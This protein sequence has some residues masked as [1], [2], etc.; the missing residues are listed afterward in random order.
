M[1][2]KATKPNTMTVSIFIFIV[3][4][5]T[6]TAVQRFSRFERL[7]VDPNNVTCYCEPDRFNTICLFCDS[8]EAVGLNAE[9]ARAFMDKHALCGEIKREKLK[10]TQTSEVN[11][12]IYKLTDSYKTF[13]IDPNATNAFFATDLL[14]LGPHKINI[15]VG[16]SYEHSIT[17]GVNE[18]GELDIEYEGDT[19]KPAMYLFETYIKDIC[20]TYIKEHCE[21][22]S[23]PV[24]SAV[25]SCELNTGGEVQNKK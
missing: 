18:S 19:N 7:P 6:V 10:T 3:A 2:A 9:E 20:D 4:G 15:S 22:V 23:L 16:E 13:Q 24:V 8:T 11:Q 5:L 12:D 25:K 1:K 21:P 17:F 14:N